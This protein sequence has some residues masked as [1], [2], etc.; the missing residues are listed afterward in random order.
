MAAYGASKAAIAQFTRTLALE[1]APHGVRV[2]AVAPGYIETD[3]TAGL[4]RHAYWGDVIRGQIPVG[5]PGQ[6]ADIVPVVLY[7]ASPAARY[8]TGQ[9]FIVDG[10]YTTK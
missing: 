10:G 8:T 4:L 6:P 3:M 9:L 7:L 2:N 5:E 1:F